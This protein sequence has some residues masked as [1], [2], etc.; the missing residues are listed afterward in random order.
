MSRIKTHS[1][2]DVYLFGRELGRGAYSIVYEGLHKQTGRKFAIKQLLK[3]KIVD[4]NKVK[5][6]EINI[7]ASVNHPHVVHLEEVYE[8]SIY[9]HLVLE[10]VEGGELFDKIIKSGHFTETQT[11]SIVSQVLSALQYL[12]GNNIVHRDLKPENLL[13]KENTSVVLIADFGFATR[14][15]GDLQQILT[16]C[17]SLH[18]T[19]PEILLAQPYGPAVD[20]WSVGVI[21]YVL[22]TGCFPWEGD[23]D[24]LQ[25]ILSQIVNAS[26]QFPKNISISPSA[27]HLITKL[28]VRDPNARYT[29][30]EALNHPW[31]QGKDTSQ[32]MMHPSYLNLLQNISK[33]SKD[34]RNI[35]Y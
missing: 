24:D 7:M 10:L 2:A 11:S 34:R 25:G 3:E 6:R 32:L 18:Y 19:A 33:L 35:S 28:I 20:M 4:L 14:T 26:F 29:A 8:D 9:L 27:K 16:Q 31:V 17:G 5:D 30:E 21:I 12:H 23:A 1:I 22:L 13:C 15:G